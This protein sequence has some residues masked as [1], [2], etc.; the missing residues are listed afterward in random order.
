MNRSFLAEEI[1][2][3]IIEDFSDRSG[4]GDEW[5]QIDKAMKAEIK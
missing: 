5:G 1:V 2:K 4:L 3:Q